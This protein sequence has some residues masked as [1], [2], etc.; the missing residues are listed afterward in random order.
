MFYR[1]GGIVLETQINNRYFNQLRFSSM[2]M[3]KLGRFYPIVKLWKANIFDDID[4]YLTP[5]LS[6]E[7]Q[8]TC[9][10]LI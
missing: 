4:R 5:S 1:R 9:F 10:Y 3:I 8:L 6:I 2:Y 7:Y